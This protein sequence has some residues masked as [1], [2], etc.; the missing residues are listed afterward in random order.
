MM[1]ALVF[2]AWLLATLQPFV[3]ANDCVVISDADAVKN[4]PLLTTT[5]FTADI[6]MSST[7][8][9]RVIQIMMYYSQTKNQI[10][11]NMLDNG[12]LSDL[13]FYYEDQEV[14]GIDYS[15]GRGNCTAKKLSDAPETFMVGGVKDDAKIP[16]ALGV[17]RMTGKSGFNDDNI[18]VKHVGQAVFRDMNVEQYESCQRWAIN[19]QELVFKVTHYFSNA[20]TWKLPSDQVIPIAMTLDGTGTVRGQSVQVKHTYSFFNFQ[21]SVV[22]VQLETPPGV[23]CRREKV[24]PFPPTPNYIQ[25]SAEVIDHANGAYTF[26]EEI[27]ST[28]DK[29]AVMRLQKSSDL[30]SD[31][32]INKREIL[33]DFTSGLSFIVDK[34]VGTCKVMNITQSNKATPLPFY[35]VQDDGK[36][37]QLSPAKF[38]YA[39]GTEYHYLGERNVRG[40]MSDTFVTRTTLLNSQTPSNLATIEW[41][42]AKHATTWNDN[43]K[44]YKDQKLQIPVKFRMWESDTTTYSTDMNIYDVDFTR[45]KLGVFDVR[46]CFPDSAKNHFQ[47]VLEGATRDIVNRYRENFLSKAMFTIAD[48]AQVL[49]WRVVGLRLDITQSQVLFEFDIM[50]QPPYAGDVEQSLYTPVSL[51]DATKNLIDSVRRGL[52]LMAYNPDTK[53]FDKHLRMSNFKVM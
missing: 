35:T 48:Q 21:F 26:L 39:F 45:L 15:I 47:T 17:L 7:E 38:F 53:L 8:T 9:A 14:L 40:I 37:K 20:T 12:Q 23:F 19:G 18:K 29:F 51:E 11:L 13:F 1:R 42:F 50:N 6:E 44:S 33:Q 32:G 5:E 25:F 31:K 22:P 2:F 3:T 41:Y 46:P 30:G 10:R 4:L 49:W 24:Y 34:K 52:S 28:D 43:S 16:S 27:F 36:I